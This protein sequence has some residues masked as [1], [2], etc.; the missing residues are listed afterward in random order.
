MLETFRQRLGRRLAPAANLINLGRDPYRLLEALWREHGD[1]FDFLLAGQRPVVVCADP[2]GVRELVTASYESA[3]R[4][5]GGVELFVDPLSLILLDDEPHR[6]HR[7]LLGPSFNAEAVRAF[8]P[9][10]VEITD[11]SLDR[12]P[13]DRPAPLL[14]VMQ[15]ITMRV[16]LRC[17]LGVDEGPRFEELRTL[18]VEYMRMVFS[19]EMVA[20]GAVSLPAR[21]RAS[22]VALSRRA[23]KIAA[24]APFTPSRLPYRRIGDR[25]GRIEAILEAEITERRASGVDGR[26]DVLSRM[27][28]ARQADGSPLAPADLLAQLFML[29]I[30]GYETTSL[31][32]CWAVHALLQHPE[33]LARARA[34]VDAVMGA[35]F[36]AGRVRELHYLS[37]TI[38]ESM[39]LYPI[40]IGVSRELRRPMTIAGRDLP[41]GTVVMAN[42]FLTQRHPSLWEDPLTFRPERMLERRPAPHL[43]FPFGVG[44]WRCLGAAFAEHELRIVL[45]RLLARLDVEAAPGAPVHAEQRSVAAGPSGGLPVILRARRTP[46]AASA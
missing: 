32:L 40:A 22:I 24:D 16:I 13:L 36:D 39:R 9:T 37:A 41:I 34:E 38:Y 5:A 1:V 11:R 43:F 28:A 33:V 17:L 3:S 19:P 15:D 26:E 14:P 2:Q 12:A 45:A 21:A 31:S 20:L 25:L 10:M 44:V 46:A 8:G 35:G 7:K 30:G 42:I 27:I 4:Y 18:V 6:G 23:R 29:I